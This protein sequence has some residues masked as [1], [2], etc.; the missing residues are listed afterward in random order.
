MALDLLSSPLLRLFCSNRKGRTSIGKGSQFKIVACLRSLFFSDEGGIALLRD[1]EIIEA[2]RRMQ[3]NSRLGLGMDGPNR[4]C[5]RFVSLLV[6]ELN[7][8]LWNLLL[9]NH[10][11]IQIKKRQCFLYPLNTAYN[12]AVGTG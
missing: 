11:A 2:R 4:A 1:I 3:P 12:A 7:K 9:F 8:L 10:F 5:L 6:C